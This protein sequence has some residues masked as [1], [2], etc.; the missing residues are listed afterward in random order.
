M[1]R[2]RKFYFS[3]MLIAFFAV[4][5]SLSSSTA[6]AALCKAGDQAS[7]LWKG[8]WYP[9]YV[10]KAQANQCFIHYTG[11]N[12]SWDEW[13]GPSRIRITSRSTSSSSSAFPVG[14]AVKVKWKGTWYPAHVKKSQADKWYIHY[15]GYSNSWD[16][17]VGRS[18]IRY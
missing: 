8:K 5:V 3:M 13:V 12:N 7:V 17:W 11:Y 18:R 9:A 16:E 6:E 15:D 4:G 10:K 1:D 2:T 14:A